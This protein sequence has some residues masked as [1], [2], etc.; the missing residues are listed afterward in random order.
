[1][2]GR[3]FRPIDPMAGML[4]LPYLV[5]VGLAAA[6]NVTRNVT[7]AAMNRSPL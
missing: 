2:P 7:S 1:M 3:A 5:R 4:F 6:L